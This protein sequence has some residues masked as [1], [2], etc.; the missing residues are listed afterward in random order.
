[1]RNWFDGRNGPSGEHLVDLVRH[2]D[3]VLEALLA[4]CGRNELVAAHRVIDT[5]RELKQIIGH[6][7]ELFGGPDRG[8]S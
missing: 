4:M 2:S 3:E 6:L 5:R 1:V 7:D 8:N